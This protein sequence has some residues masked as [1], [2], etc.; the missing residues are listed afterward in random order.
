MTQ[1]IYDGQGRQVGVKQSTFEIPDRQAKIRKSFLEGPGKHHQEASQWSKNQ[2][3]ELLNALRT[4]ADIEDRNRGKVFDAWNE[5]NKRIA[6]QILKNKETE[7]K[8][9]R[10]EADNFGRKGRA[11]Q[12][13]AP[14]IGKVIDEGNRILDEMA[15]IKAKEEMAKGDGAEDESPEQTR[16]LMAQEK[17]HNDLTEGYITGPHRLPLAVIRGWTGY[18]Q[19]VKNHIKDIHHKR[20][21]TSQISSFNSPGGGASEAFFELPKIGMVN[22]VTARNYIKN[23]PQKERKIQEARLW[24]A[25][26]TQFRKGLKDLYGLTNKRYSRFYRKAL[27]K[28]HDDYVRN[29]DNKAETDAIKQQSIDTYEG[30]I[31]G[32]YLKYREKY[33]E[34]TS[35]AYTRRDFFKTAPSSWTPKETQNAFDI[36]VLA[37]IHAGE[38]SPKLARSYVRVQVEP[39]QWKASNDLLEKQGKKRKLQSIAKTFPRSAEAILNAADAKEN[40]QATAFGAER[41][42]NDNLEKGHF[43]EAVRNLAQFQ[44]DNPFATREQIWA[45]FNGSMPGRS[46]WS[47]KTL[48]EVQKYVLDDIVTV[49]ETNGKTLQFSYE[50]MVIEGHPNIEKVID[51]WPITN[52]KKLELKRD[53][54]SRGGSMSN[55]VRKRWSDALLAATRPWIINQTQDEK[56][57]DWRWHEKIRLTEAAITERAI[58]IRAG[59][60]EL[61]GMAN[62][63]TD[64]L[65]D[66]AY[67]IAFEEIFTNDFKN[68]K[69]DG[70]Y[71]S[72]LSVTEATQAGGYANVKMPAVTGPVKYDSLSLLKRSVERDGFTYEDYMTD[73]NPPENRYEIYPQMLKLE[74]SINTGTP[75]SPSNYVKEAAYALGM[76]PEKF[77]YISSVK[78]NNAGSP[79]P[80]KIDWENTDLG[81]AEAALAAASPSVRQLL[82]DQLPSKD[83]TDVVMAYQILTDLD[84]GYGD[85]SKLAENP[86]LFQRFTSL[87]AQ[88][89][90]ERR[91]K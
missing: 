89:I 25:T 27:A 23:L 6:S 68:R 69:E 7:I 24:G 41:K 71:W 88:R 8:N 66:K 73:G 44:E 56:Q 21:A 77:V 51:G 40:E 18:S 76:T 29:S 85:V 54:K 42:K 4:K 82:P 3:N 45:Y 33:D 19:R 70:N 20:T 38:I 58:A 78:W 61:P 46:N 67:Q 63:S 16:A 36:G 12:T 28:D 74:E 47:N 48:K 13:L 80:V 37:G 79:K 59:V 15:E 9:L 39:R 49:Y 81:K 5:D 17:E 62:A 60:A 34:K 10:T 65:W 87:A 83:A 57:I 52:K 26:E 30:R 55:P 53:L 50:R 91:A 2:S 22:L 43:D 64:E 1:V 14:S 84:I 90:L 75:Y 86:E 72:A 32:P 31:K 35:L 11:L